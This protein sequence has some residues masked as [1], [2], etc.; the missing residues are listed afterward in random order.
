M[1]TMTPKT[2]LRNNAR[3]AAPAEPWIVRH[4]QQVL[5]ALGVALAAVLLTAVV[6]SRLKRAEL[7]SWERISLSLSQAAEGRRAEALATLDAALAAKRSGPPAVQALLIKSD[8]L[9]ADG[10]KDEALAAAREARRQASSKE[11][12]A[13]TSISLAYA[14]DQSGNPAL[15][16]E[17]YERFINEN[18]DHFIVPRASFQLARLKADQGDI[19]A[20]RAAYEK[21]VTLYPSTIWARDA[22]EALEAL[23][24]SK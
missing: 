16:A 23:N 13:L 1:K 6:T 10:K 11:Y 18:P 9:L 22:K 3:P 21:L 19:P 8:L 20:A 7:A 5:L 24:T 12:V 2:P 17:E 15:A 4:W 14:L